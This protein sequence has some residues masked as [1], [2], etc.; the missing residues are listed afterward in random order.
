MNIPLQITLRDMEHSD[1]LEARIKKDVAK[2]ELLHP[3]IT[4]C[5]VTVDQ[6]GRHPQKGRQFSVHVEVRAPGHE[7]VVS[8]RKHHEDVY[9][10]VRDAFGSVRRHLEEDVREARGDVK[11]HAP[12]FHGTVARLDTEEGFG[13]I[14]TDDGREVYFTRENVVH[15]PFEHLQE[16][17]EVQFIEEPAGE[18]MQ[19]RRVSVGKHGFQG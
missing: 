7:D 11:S 5:R 1:A 19:A 15:P 3:R 12:T 6:A 2:L 13:F 10:A 17:A 18:G 8:T 14:E 16:G 4:S 9:V